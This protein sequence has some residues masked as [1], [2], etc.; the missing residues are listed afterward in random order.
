MKK[1]LKKI[2][3]VFTALLL[4]VMPLSL[5]GCKSELDKIAETTSILNVRYYSGGLGEAWINQVKSEF[6][7]LLKDVSFEEGKTGVYINITADKNFTDIELTVSS[8]A[9]KNDIYYTPDN[10]LYEHYGAGVTM[11]VT[12]IFTEKVY[13]DNGGVVLASDG[14]SFVVQSQSMRDRAK[15]LQKDVFNMGTTEDPKYMAI[16]YSDTIT[17]IIVDY[18]LFKEEGWTDYTGMYG[19]P[20]TFDEF[21]NLLKKIQRA[22]YSAF[23]YSVDH[24]ARPIEKAIIQKVDG[25]EGTALWNTYTGEYDFTYDENGNK[26]EPVTRNIAPQSAWNLIYT[27]GY[28]AA[29]DFSSLMFTSDAQGNS[30]YDANVMQGVTYT[31]AQSEF[32]MSKTYTDGRNRIAMIVEGDWWENEARGTFNSMGQID[33]DNG[34]GKRDF[35][36]M[37]IPQM[38]EDDKCEQ[39]TIGSHS[40]AGD[41]LFVNKLTVEN[42]PVKRLLTK[43]WLQFQYSA[44]GCRTFTKNS[45]SVLPYAYDMTDDDLKVL[46]PFARSVWD[47]HTDPRVQIVHFGSMMQSY[48]VRNASQQVVFN[49]SVLKSGQVGGTRTSFTRDIMF[50]N[51][52]QMAQKGYVYN[53]G[54]WVEGAKEY[55]MDRISRA[56]F[57]TQQ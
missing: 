33:A 32:L 38:T 4:S 55:L 36:F 43:L 27:R 26:I 54:E 20:G 51:A 13:D 19:L 45:G 56:T 30:Y 6:E 40:G 14:K 15:D 37:P 21:E 44:D 50:E 9:D 16:P 22:G 52:R 31:G 39:Y 41:I 53:W 24:Y 1:L 35:K 46:T 28:K 47:M 29:Y 57:P 17:G 8:G 42:N 11:D 25:D 10:N 18:D 34:Y 23:T 48:T 7:E 49:A 12:D 5:A 2:T 3:V